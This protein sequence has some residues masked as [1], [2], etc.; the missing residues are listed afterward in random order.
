MRPALPGA[1]NK[2]FA[3]ERR[4]GPVQQPSRSRWV[5][6]GVASYAYCI[7]TVNNATCDTSWVSVGSATSAQVSS[8]AAG[9]TYY[10]QVVRATNGFGTTDANAGTWWS[11]STL[12]LPAAFNKSTPANGAANQSTSPTPDGGRQHRRRLLRYCIDTVNDNA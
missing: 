1:F 8:L 2:T 12:S 11:L 5:S 10:W 6:S 7:D 4:D 9:T 3:G